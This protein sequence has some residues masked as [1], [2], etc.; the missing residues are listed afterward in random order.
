[1]STTMSPGISIDTKL[2][3]R[4]FLKYDKRNKTT[5]NWR[6]KWSLERG[7]KFVFYWY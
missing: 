4:I 1:M 5:S 3:Q 6:I 2:W 7:K